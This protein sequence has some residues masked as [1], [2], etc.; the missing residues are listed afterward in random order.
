MSLQPI[1]ERIRELWKAVAITA[2]EHVD[3]ASAA[4]RADIVAMEFIKRFAP[5][6][7]MAREIN[8]A[9]LNNVKTP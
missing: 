4:A 2:A 1:D 3:G 9:L 8:N 6:D 5:N 7:T